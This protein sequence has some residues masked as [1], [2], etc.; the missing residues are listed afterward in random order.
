MNWPGPTVTD[1]GGFQVMSLGHMRKITEEGVVFKSH[2]D[3]SL[4]NLTPENRGLLHLMWV[5]G[6]A[7]GAGFA[8]GGLH[9]AEHR[10]AVHVRSAAPRKQEGDAS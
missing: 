8:A 1:S 9:V 4:V 2:L 6:G 7:T 10:R 3:G 5:W